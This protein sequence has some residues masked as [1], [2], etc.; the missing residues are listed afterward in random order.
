MA[1]KNIKPLIFILDL[2]YTIGDQKPLAILA[3]HAAHAASKL[4]KK[5]LSFIYQRHMS[6]VTIASYDF[7]ASQW[8]PSIESFA[9]YM[10]GANYKQFIDIQYKSEITV[11][12]RDN[13]FTVFKVSTYDMNRGLNILLDFGDTVSTNRFTSKLLKY[14]RNES[15]FFGSLFL[16][17][18]EMSWSSPQAKSELLAFCK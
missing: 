15:N 16:P 6:P 5:K 13:N 9:E 17:M 7:N 10:I 1:L 11:D 8:L 14:N 3:V 4:T 2:G 12:E 18:D